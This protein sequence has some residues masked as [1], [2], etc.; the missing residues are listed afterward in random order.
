MVI[1]ATYRRENCTLKCVHY[2]PIL[3]GGSFNDCLNHTPDLASGS[4]SGMFMY[5]KT[6]TIWYAYIKEHGYLFC[7]VIFIL[8]RSQLLLRNSNDLH[9]FIVLKRNMF[10]LANVFRIIS[11]FDFGVLRLW[12]AC[13]QPHDKR[14][15]K[16]LSLPFLPTSVQ[17]VIESVLLHWS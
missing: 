6:R 3:W 13:N 9:Y 5:I 12:E 14:R 7:L 2:Y 16:P 17:T 1:I 10:V 11:I 15:I 4:I 8:L